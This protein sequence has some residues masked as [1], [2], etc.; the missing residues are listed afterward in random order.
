MKNEQKQVD[1]IKRIYVIMAVVALLQSAYLVFFHDE[2]HETTRPNSVD[3]PDILITEITV[4]QVES[5]SQSTISA[6]KSELSHDKLDIYRNQFKTLEHI[7]PDSV[8]QSISWEENQERKMIVL[9]FHQGKVIYAEVHQP[10][11]MPASMAKY[12]FYQNQLLKADLLSGKTKAAGGKNST[13]V[14]QTNWRLRQ[15]FWFDEQGNIVDSTKNFK[16][17]TLLARYQNC[18]VC[19]SEAKM[20]LDNAPDDWGK[21]VDEKLF[22]LP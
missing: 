2:P 15:S 7:M 18:A 1:R 11:S 14:T 22:K 10:D 9:R 4:G 17:D 6:E 19:A 8:P 16:D 12:W 13:G 5:K 20:I 21:P 3:A